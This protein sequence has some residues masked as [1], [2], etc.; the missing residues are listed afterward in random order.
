MPVSFSLFNF[1][2]SLNVFFSFSLF[3]L[4]FYHYA[5]S[6]SYYVFMLFSFSLFNF[7]LCLYDCLFSLFNFVLCLYACFVFSVQFCIM[8]IC[9]FRFLCSI[10]YC[11][12][13]L[14]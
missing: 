6:V 14:D 11:V 9:V 4:L 13:M 5:C 12:F 7:I 10:L 1:V 8:S 2:F 3:S